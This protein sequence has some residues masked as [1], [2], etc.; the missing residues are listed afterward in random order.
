MKHEAQVTRVTKRKILLT[1]EDVLQLLKRC[2]EV[3]R[4]VDGF[5]L[6]TV[7][8][9]AGN[10]AILSVAWVE[11]EGDPEESISVDPPAAG[12]RELLHNEAAQGPADPVG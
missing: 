4:R 12:D 11:E 7:Q 9:S 10:A 5:E 8:P 6:R 3:P 1:P 2:R